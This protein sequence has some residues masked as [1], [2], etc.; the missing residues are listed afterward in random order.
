M[1]CDGVQ[2]VPAAKG[3]AHRQ[4]IELPYRLYRGDPRFV[5]PLRRERRQ[6]FSPS[7][8]FF[9]HAEAAFFLARR[10]GRVVGR[11][12]AV[13]NHR[14]AALHERTTGFFGAY[15]CE[16][17]REASNA[18]LEAAAAWL[19]ARGMTVMRG[20]FTHSQ[21]EE[22]GLLID[23]FEAPP[24]F[25]LSYNPPYYAQLLEGHGLTKARDHHAWWASVDTRIE[26]RF[27]RA[28]EAVRKRGRVTIRPLRLSDYDAEVARAEHLLNASLAA[29][30]GFVPVTSAELRFA[31]RQSRALLVPELVL[32][33]EVGGVPAGMAL[34]MPDVNQA[35][36]G[37]PDGRLFPFGWWRLAR[38]ARA[39]DQ[40]RLLALGVLP[41]YRNR[42]IELL[43]CLELLAAARRLGYRGGELSLTAEDNQAIERVITGMGARR[44]KTYRIYERRL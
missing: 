43:L 37:V 31:A 28:A 13:I 30:G 15:D 22:Y 11:I 41:A 5:P 7:H 19:R 40:A 3:A 34:A 18:L 36:A 10:A 20:P 21:N 8:P 14:Y 27:L 42:G 33:A 12:E 39:I 9:A 35:L 26:P 25:Q 29:T 32:F 4:F 1:A 17:D 44:Y 6:L 16:H 2:I 24:T 38:A 23:G